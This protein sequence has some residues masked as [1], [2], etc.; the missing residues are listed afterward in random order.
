MLLFNSFFYIRYFCKFACFS[1]IHYILTIFSYIKPR[2]IIILELYSINF[3]IIRLKG[4]TDDF[5]IMTG[6]TF[7]VLYQTTLFTVFRIYKVIIVFSLLYYII[8]K[9]VAVIYPVWVN[10]FTF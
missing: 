10:V 7:I 8:V 9:I 5:I 4:V 6:K 3:N 1:V 2:E